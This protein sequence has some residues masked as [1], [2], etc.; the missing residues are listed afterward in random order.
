MPS[1]SQ[2][3]RLGGRTMNGKT[4][5]EAV[6][7]TELLRGDHRR[8]RELFSDFES[9]DR[10]TKNYIA[11]TAIDEIELHTLLE[12]KLFYPAVRSQVEEAGELVAESVEAHHLAKI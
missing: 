4:T 7:A 5:V 1:H 12:E 11:R 9:L 8:I 3:R 2:R 6:S 10:E